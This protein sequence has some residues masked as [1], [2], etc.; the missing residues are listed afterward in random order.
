MNIRFV[1]SLS[2]EDECR[3]V[4]VVLGS[5]VALLDR[6]PLAYSLKVVTSGGRAF[7]HMH[8]PDAASGHRS[9]SPQPDETANA[10]FDTEPLAEVPSL[11]RR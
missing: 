2:P 3:I 7:E 6:L 1:S 4:K 8:W 9:P 5:V 10:A 11:N